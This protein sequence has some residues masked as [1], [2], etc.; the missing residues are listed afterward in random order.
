M[1]EKERN[2]GK[3]HVKAL[4]GAALVLFLVSLGLFLGS[5]EKKEAPV[6]SSTAFSQD[7]LSSRF[8]ADLGSPTTVV[9][10]YPQ[11][12]QDGYKIFLAI[13][14]SCHTSAR[15]LNSTYIKAY[16]WKRFVQ[17]MHVKMGNNKFNFAKSDEKKIVEFLV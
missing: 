15:P 8:P 13:C 6:S 7:Q 17:R 10:G 5:C 2:C 1:N 4:P 16:D 9:S 12:I 14:S 11:E 3:L